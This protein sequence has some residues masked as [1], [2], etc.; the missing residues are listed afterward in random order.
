MLRKNHRSASFN[1]LI[2]PTLREL[3][4]QHSKLEFVTNNLQKRDKDLFEI[5]KSSLEKG[6]RERATIYANEIAEIR[7]VLSVI[8]NTK[9][10]LEKAIVR[11]ETIKEI[12]PT[13]SELR[14][15]FGDVKNVLKLV[16]E[17]MPIITPE[18]DTLNNLVTEIL[19]TTQPGSVPIIEPIVIKDGPTEAILQEAAEK[20]GQDLMQ[21]M[22]EPPK[23]ITSGPTETTKPM[24]ALTTSG[25][26]IYPNTAGDPFLTNSQYSHPTPENSSSLIEEL[27]LDYIYRHEGELDITRCAEELG[28]QQNEVLSMLDILNS[29]GKIRIQQ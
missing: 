16:T 5:C 25:S 21:K 4:K 18:I 19:S 20:V 24:I 29:E 2:L 11:L 1:D 7:K 6:Q 15:L 3:S 8:A 12:C 28:I 13:M 10:V 9:L 17:V 14:G 23:A 27:V 26:E 22:P